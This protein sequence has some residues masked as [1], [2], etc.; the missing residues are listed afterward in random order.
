MASPRDLK[1]KFRD[2]DS[3]NAWYDPGEGKVTVCYSFIEEV[4]NLFLRAEGTAPIMATGM[5]P[6]DCRPK[7]V[8]YLVGT[9]VANLP[10]EQ[11][12]LAATAR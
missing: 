9:R 4:T 1:I 7:G 8:A 5:M 10:T 12:L 3:T 11:G 6:T 2:C